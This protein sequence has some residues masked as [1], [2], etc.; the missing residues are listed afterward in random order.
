MTHDIDR[1]T[2]T[3]CATC[4]R[5]IQFYDEMKAAIAASDVEPITM[6]TWY[7]RGPDID[8]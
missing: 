3:D 7:P 6:R 2:D 8:H 5:I 1:C 4:N